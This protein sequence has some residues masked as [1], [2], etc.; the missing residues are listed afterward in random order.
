MNNDDNEYGG[1]G[2]YQN[3][4]SGQHQRNVIG[5][6]ESTQRRLQSK[7]NIFRAFQQQTAMTS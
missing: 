5:N 6:T 2:A 3:L 7:K 1:D 4:K